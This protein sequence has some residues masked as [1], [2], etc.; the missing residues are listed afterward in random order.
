M[1]SVVGERGIN[2]A[3][4]SVMDVYGQLSTKSQRYIEKMIRTLA[5]QEAEKSGGPAPVVMAPVLR[6]LPG[7]FV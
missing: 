1:H 3:P 2:V 5:K 6:L 7:R 4:S